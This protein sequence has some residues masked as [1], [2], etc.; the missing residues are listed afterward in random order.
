[1]ARDYSF[2]TL[3]TYTHTHQKNEKKKKKTMNWAP[4]STISKTVISSGLETTVRAS[5]VTVQKIIRILYNH[6]RKFGKIQ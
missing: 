1:M 3:N 6:W 2:S 5:A 4:M